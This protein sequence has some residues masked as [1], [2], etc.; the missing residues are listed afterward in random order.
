VGPQPLFGSSENPVAS[1]QCN[2]RIGRA[3]FGLDALSGCDSDSMALSYASDIFP[4][5]ALDLFTS[6]CFPFANDRPSVAVLTGAEPECCTPCADLYD[7]FSF[8]FSG[9]LPDQC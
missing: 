8:L 4:A 5:E 3:G 1:S 2:S 9:L 6:T 7:V